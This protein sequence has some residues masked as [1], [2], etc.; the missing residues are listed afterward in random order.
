MSGRADIP[1]AERIVDLR[2]EG[3][4]A[5]LLTVALCVRDGGDHLADGFADDLFGGWRGDLELVVVDDGS[6]DDTLRILRDL[7][8]RLGATA[9]F[10]NPDAVGPGVA[11]AQAVRAARGR[12]IWFADCDDEFDLAAVLELADQADRE[13]FD[14]AVGRAEAVKD[15]RML[16]TLIDDVDPGVRDGREWLRMLLRGDVDGYL[17]NK[18]I[19]RDLAQAAPGLPLLRTQE[20]FCR[21]VLAA[22][23]TRRVLFSART[24]Y[25]YRMHDSSATRTRT[26]E[27]GNLEASRDYL[28]GIAT[29]ELAGDPD[30]PV[31]LA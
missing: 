6:R 20:D 17:W 8:R 14:A 15:G 28:V 19:S 30:L 23:R 26:P 9:V 1:L 4:D 24:V 3:P 21:V 18:V 2:Q 25:R 13:G 7:A 11:R 29:A 12:Y 27:L 16:P 31:L 10:S 5:P 22:S